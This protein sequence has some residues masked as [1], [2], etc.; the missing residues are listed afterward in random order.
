MS[1]WSSIGNRIKE[2]LYRMTGAKTIEQTLKVAPIISSRMENA[3]KLWNAMYMDESPWLHTPDGGNP[4]RITSLGIPSLIASEKA[5]MALLEWKSDITTPTKEVEEDNDTYTPPDE[6]SINAAD[7]KNV[8]AALP[9]TTKSVPIGN[10]ERAEYLQ[11]QYAKFKEKIRTQLEYGI[12]K[13]GLVVKPYPVFNKTPDSKPV[14]EFDFIQADYFYPMAVKPNGDIT[15]AAFIQTKTAKDTVYRRLEYHKWLGDS[16]EIQNRAFKVENVKNFDNAQD[17]DLGVEIPLS[18]V[19]EWAN[20]ERTVVIN[21]VDRPLFAYF[22]MPEANTVDPNSPLGVSGFSRAVN[23]IKDADIQYSTLLWEYEGG[24]MAIDVDRMAFEYMKDPKTGE[25]IHDMGSRQ[26]RLYR[27]IDLGD[28]N[29]YNAFAPLLRDGSYLDGLNN[30]LMRIEDATSLSRGTL[31]DQ[32]I[33]EARTATELKILK[34]R[35]Y[36]ANQDIQTALE[37]MIRDMVYI[38]DVYCTLYNITPPGDY[39]ISFDWDDSILTDKDDELGKRI[40]LQQNG[41][42]SK[43][44][45][46]MWYFGET[47]RQAKEALTRIMQESLQQAQADI[48]LQKQMSASGDEIE[49]PNSINDTSEM[50]NNNTEVE[51]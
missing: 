49:N 31:S 18:Q 33:S 50:A 43:L 27:K 35:S 12:A 48:L 11:K 51:E 7:I 38:M 3:I 23:L 47:E 20:L 26:R 10:T 9:H 16:V 24:Q 15:E 21:N 2:F 39:D 29:T 46:R 45:N 28:D 37:N 40:T 30:I 36:A 22:K 25:I 4:D 17:L 1:F 32:V 6:N 5:R 19:P 8:Y 44:E 13:G 14:I 34:Q 41:L 42:T